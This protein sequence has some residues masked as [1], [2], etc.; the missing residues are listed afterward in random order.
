MLPLEPSQAVR[1]GREIAA[2]VGN[3]LLRHAGEAARGAQ[4]AAGNFN[5]R[6]VEIVCAA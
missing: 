5:N 4:H 2:P 6:H 1:Q 3:L